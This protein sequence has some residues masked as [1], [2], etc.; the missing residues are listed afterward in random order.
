MGYSIKIVCQLTGIPRATLHT[1]E[2][3]HGVVT[4]DRADN[5]YREYSDA[6]VATLLQVKRLVDAGH[7]IREAVAMTRGAEPLAEGSAPRS[8]RQPLVDALLAMDTSAA[9][10]SVHQLVGYSYASLL[11]DVYLP[12]LCEVGDRWHAGTASVAQEHFASAYL[13]AQLIAMMQRIGAGPLG[14]AVAVVA[15]YPGEQHEL[16]LISVAIRLALAGWRVVYLGADLPLDELQRVVRAR[17]P[18]LVCQS[19]VTHRGAGEVLAHAKSL[20]DS[21]PA[22]THLAI[23]GAGASDLTQMASGRLLVCS[24]FADLQRW[25]ASHLS[26]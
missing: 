4:P 7:P 25:T 1:W 5:A 23:G 12:A 26:D 19:I 21:A 20:L 14:G 16:G 6:D 8:L 22:R 18:Q 24:S 17:G 11:D 3:R 10:S 13:R 9:D 2:R 15:G